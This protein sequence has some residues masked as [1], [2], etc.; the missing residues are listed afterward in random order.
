MGK[1]FYL[2]LLERVVW[3]AIQAAGAEWV[4]TGMSFDAQTAKVAGAAALASAVKC[5]LASRVGDSQSAAAFP[6][7]D[8]G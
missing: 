8:G 7:V 6:G 2:D 5:L 3:T 4:A 1:K